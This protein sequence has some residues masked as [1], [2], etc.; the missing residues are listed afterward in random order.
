MKAKVRENI[1]EN[2]VILSHNLKEITTTSQLIICFFFFFFDNLAS[3][4][5][6]LTKCFL[7]AFAIPFRAL[8]RRDPGDPTSLSRSAAS[9]S[10]QRQRCRADLGFSCLFTHTW[11]KKKN[12]QWRNTYI[13]RNCLKKKKKNKASGVRNSNGLLILTCERHPRLPGQQHPHHSGGRQ[14]LRLLLGPLLSSTLSVR[15]LFNHTVPPVGGLLLYWLTHNDKTLKAQTFL[16]GSCYGKTVIVG[17]FYFRNSY[18][19]N[20]PPWDIT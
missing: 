4:L 16:L 3:P 14:V 2:I 20:K 11:E 13:F 5:F 8:P 17:L 6:F 18:Q 1:L 15:E 12:T 9:L 10:M 19:K 7:Q